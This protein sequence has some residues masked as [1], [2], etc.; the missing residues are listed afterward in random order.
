MP[1][2]FVSIALLGLAGLASAAKPQ[3]EYEVTLVPTPPEATSQVSRV[4]RLNNHG[5]ALAIRCRPA[6]WDGA[7]CE[8]FLWSQQEGSR[9]VISCLLGSNCNN[10]YLSVDNI[11]VLLNERGEVGG[12][13]NG[14][15]FAWSDKGGM[16]AYG[17]VDAVY[18]MTPTLWFNKRAE[19]SGFALLYQPWTYRAYLASDAGIQYVPA[20]WSI[21]AGLND[22]SEMA[23]T[24]RDETG[25]AQAFYS[26]SKGGIVNIGAQIGASTSSA[27]GIDE[28]GL[29]L[30]T[31][32]DAAPAQSYFLWNR[33]RG[34][35]GTMA[36][37]TPCD[38]P[39][40]AVLSERAILLA[41]GLSPRRLWLWTRDTGAREVGSLGACEQAGR[42]V[43]LSSREA[44]LT[45]G[46][47][48]GRV[49]LWTSEAGIR[50]VG[51][52]GYD[53]TIRVANRS[54][55]LAGYSR[56]V[57][58]GPLR[59]FVWTLATGLIDLNAS[60]ASASIAISVINDAGV[61]GGSLDGRAAIWAP[62][63]KQR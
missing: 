37:P 32:S 47:R 5:E 33:E 44:L 51:S 22:N 57:P 2:S 3:L 1:I 45:C 60:A 29:V 8:E 10:Y 14:W 62:A 26:T 40:P 11:P 28:Q 58:G 4:V 21:P 9:Q 36:V 49:A 25:P 50:D 13:P 34:L 17:K 52:V 15:I 56:R 43:V 38:L 19:I 23:G 30:G 16:K 42:I 18:A 46:V 63:W 31:R 54:G 41:C 7:Q 6:Y 24:M 20:F 27:L 39:A 48:E 59:A 61:I 12:N 35:L 55:V 53:V